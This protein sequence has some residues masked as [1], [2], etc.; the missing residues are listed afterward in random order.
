MNRADTLQINASAWNKRTQVHVD[1]EFYAT[2][3]VLSG[4]SSIQQLD[5]A[6]LGNIAG[7]KLLH[8]QCHFGLDTISLAR[9]GADCIGVDISV[10]AIEK[11]TELASQ[12]GI[13]VTFCVADAQR[14]EHVVVPSTFD[15][16][17]TSYGVL[18]WIEDLWEW[19]RGISR[20][21]KSGGR[22]ILI[23]YHPFLNVIFPGC[24][25][26]TSD[27]FNSLRG[28]LTHSTG[29]YTDR[30]S[31]IEYE[32]VRWAH[33]ISEIHAALSAA[34]LSITHLGEHSFSPYPIV[35]TLAEYDNNLWRE[36]EGSEK[37]PYLM[38]LCAVKP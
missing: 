33:S 36:K 23:E 26:G 7:L 18:C 29:T 19:A 27:Y 30:N 32:E 12:A 13:E 28:N 15:I 24:L 8:L 14:I 37:L 22:L 20:A 16:V 38:S 10:A 4:T 5:S 35:P 6:L 25:A 11:A 34:H 21:L 17:Y 2:D 3:K 1:S 9:M 31:D